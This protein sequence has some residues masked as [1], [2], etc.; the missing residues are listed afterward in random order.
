MIA[1]GVDV[2]AALE[3]LFDESKRKQKRTKGCGRTTYS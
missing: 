2:M 3:D 1:D